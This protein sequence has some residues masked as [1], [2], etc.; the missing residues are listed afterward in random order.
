[1]RVWLVNVGEVLP[2]DPGPKRLLRMGTLAEVLRTRGHDVM[3]W[4]STFDHV[5]KLHRFESHHLAT[6]ESGIRLR[7]LHSAGYPRNVCL[8]RLA[9]HLGLARSFARLAPAEP[10]PHL[11][12]C[13]WPTIELSWACVRY[14]A[15]RG[16]P[17]VLDVRDLWPDIFADCLPGWL[18]GAATAALLPFRAATRAAFSRCTSIV[19]ISERYLRW[20]LGHAGREQGGDDRIFP[21]GY[22]KP[23][24][25]DDARRTARAAVE[26]LGVDPS[27]TV[28]WFIGTFGETYD[29]S[30]VLETA[31]QLQQLGD[32]RTQFVLSG[33][34]RMR[35]RWEQIAW[36]LDNVVFTGWID[37]QQIAAMMDIAGVGLAA[38]RPRAPQGLPN[39]IFEYMAAGIPIL[40]SLAGECEDFLARHECGLSYQA[41]DSASFH[42]RLQALCDD[43]ELRRTLGANGL[44][45]F[46]QFYSAETVYTSMADFLEELA[47]RRS[48]ALVA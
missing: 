19:G 32:R 23:K 8:R 47:N 42:S 7:L 14:G 37:A 6:S 16:I 40:S 30:P 10:A 48:W 18:G 24:I 36:G 46:E 44:K 45:A 13:S 41:G 1:M 25:S 26:R 20:A 29:L 38:Y 4:T 3:W 43:A 34:G 5:R 21:L 11:L 9:N 15:A 28:C 22:C 17:V 2:I 31:R 39:K 33:D 35:Q 27:R 12:V